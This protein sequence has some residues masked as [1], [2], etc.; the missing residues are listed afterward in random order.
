MRILKGDKQVKD[1]QIAFWLMRSGVAPSEINNVLEWGFGKGYLNEPVFPDWFKRWNKRHPEFPV[2]ESDKFN[3]FITVIGFL[4]LREKARK[5][6][7][8]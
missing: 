1:K 5:Q 2:K 6:K 3:E 4:Y 7:E 8:N